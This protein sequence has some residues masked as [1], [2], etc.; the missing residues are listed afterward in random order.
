MSA[1]ASGD[2]PGFNPVYRS[3]DV[4]GLGEREHLRKYKCV[5][6]SLT[7]IL[8]GTDESPLFEEQKSSRARTPNIREYRVVWVRRPRTLQR[9][10][11]EEAKLVGVGV[12]TVGHTSKH[13]EFSMGLLDS[14]IHGMDIVK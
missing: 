4:F 13:P 3:L 1:Y 11:E 12:P 5:A 6:I 9:I 7:T 2:Q 10:G 8:G 14:G